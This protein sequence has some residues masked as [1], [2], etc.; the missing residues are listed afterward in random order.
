M[1]SLREDGPS[2]LTVIP[3]LVFL[4]G[5]STR[6]PCIGL[7]K[8]QAGT[9]PNSIL[10]SGWGLDP[11]NDLAVCT[12]EAFSLPTTHQ[13]SSKDCTILSGSPTVVRRSSSGRTGSKSCLTFLT[14]PVLD[15]TSSEGLL[16]ATDVTEY[17]FKDARF[18]LLI[19]RRTLEPGL[20]SEPLAE[21]AKEN[22]FGENDW[23]IDPDWRWYSIISSRVCGRGGR[24]RE[25]VFSGRGMVE[26]RSFL[27]KLAAR[28]T[29]LQA[30]VRE[31]VV[32]L[33][34]KMGRTESSPSPGV[35]RRFL[36]QD[37]WRIRTIHPWLHGVECR[38]S[39]LANQKLQGR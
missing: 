3:K 25:R 12:I 37:P 30:W 26:S 33:A 39:C 18:E 22:G 5:L 38:T 7:R 29:D 23:G 6:T 21:R 4:T 31:R 35:A 17:R 36:K 34:R 10:P 2:T 24:E 13:P 20:D 27:E 16:D 28:E 11:N 32:S 8:H 9:T 1:R 14:V 19:E 15:W